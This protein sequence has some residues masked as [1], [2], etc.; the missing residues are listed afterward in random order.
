MSYG[1]RLNL[2]NNEATMIGSK[3]LYL[4]IIL[5]VRDDEGKAL[6]TK[7][8]RIS[9]FPTKK[10]EA[11]FVGKKREVKPGEKE[12]KCDWYSATF[13]DFKPLLKSYSKTGLVK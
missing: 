5:L 3:Y 9:V 6:T 10:L 8:L 4:P 2:L 7:W 12:E 11:L 1:K 13:A